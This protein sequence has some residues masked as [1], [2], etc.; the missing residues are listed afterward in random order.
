MQNFHQIIITSNLFSI[1]VPI[2]VWFRT[3]V[4]DCFII[5]SDLCCSVQ[6]LSQV[7]SIKT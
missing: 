5:S 1:L 2:E 6:L 7:N 3:A 4:Y